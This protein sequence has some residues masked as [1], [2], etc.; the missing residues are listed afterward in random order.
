MLEKTMLGTVTPE[1]TSLLSPEKKK[2]SP[3]RGMPTAPSCLL[4]FLSFEREWIQALG[5]KTPTY[6]ARPSGG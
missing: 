5:K 3:S 6:D 1:H 2:S 4:F